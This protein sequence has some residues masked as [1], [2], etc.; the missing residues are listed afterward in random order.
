MRGKIGRGTPNGFQDSAFLS[1]TSSISTTFLKNCGRGE[2][3][4]TTTCRKTVAGGK[5][6]H[7]PCKAS[8]PPHVVKLWLGGKKG[9]VPCKASGPPHVVKLWL[10]VRKVMF[11]V[12]LWTTTCRKTV[13]GGK[14][15]HVPCKASGPP[16]V[17]KLWL[18]VRKVMFPVRPLDHHMS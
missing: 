16:H 17:V 15:G 9:H 8:G 14:K 4:S 11:P 3:L 10:G 1:S 18:G 6:G 5:K 7:V 2:S 12:G 13:A